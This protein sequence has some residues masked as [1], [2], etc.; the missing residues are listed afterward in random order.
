MV[1]NQGGIGVRR[2]D[3]ESTIKAER[4]LPVHMVVGVVKEGSGLNGGKFI[5][6]SIARC[7]GS[8]RNEAVLSVGVRAAVPSSAHA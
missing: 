5:P 7:D 4:L 1:G 2:I 8:L 6:V 3:D